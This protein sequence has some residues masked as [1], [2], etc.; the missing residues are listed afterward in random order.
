AG[1]ASGV[2]TAR[3]IRAMDR[4][5]RRVRK[6][7]PAMATVESVV[8]RLAFGFA[9]IEPESS[10]AA[11]KALVRFALDVEGELDNIGTAV[12]RRFKSRFG[13]LQRPLTLSCSSSVIRAIGTLPRPRVTVCESRPAFEGRR[14][15][16]LLR[17]NA[18]SVTLVTESQIGAA[19]DE[20]DSVVMGCDAI[21]PDG[22]IVNKMG[23]YLA[24]LAARDKHRPVIVVGDTYKL[25]QPVKASFESH[26]AAQV[27]R[28]AP[29]G[30][31]VR[32]VAFETVPGR[33]ID[34]I[35]LEDGAF[36]SRGVRP[37]WKRVSKKRAAL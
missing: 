22:S 3:Y 5:F 8:A 12:P 9:N 11:Y 24:A 18:G 17:A 34:H 36:K 10:D 30:I 23:S 6:T 27:W 7:R 26:P 1:P 16:G 37:V 4:L 20:C 13:R 21:H 35:V 19:L 2:S 32:N 15:A 14:T 33:L 25:C 28:G 31:T 29:S